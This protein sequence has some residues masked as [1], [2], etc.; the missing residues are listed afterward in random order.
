MQTQYH[1]R[2]T[3]LKWAFQRVRKQEHVK[4]HAKQHSAG[5]ED[6][7]HL[8]QQHDVIGA[9]IVRTVVAIS[10]TDRANAAALSRQSYRTVC[11][12]CSWR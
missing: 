2:S 9:A 8:L 11:H 10:F 7:N 6:P 5:Q 12:G 3:Q 4:C 1:G